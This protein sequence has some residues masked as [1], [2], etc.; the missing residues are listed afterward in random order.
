MKIIL[1][2]TTG[3]IGSE[4]LAQCVRN[5]ATSS[6][7]VL[8]RRPLPDTL[9][10]DPKVQVIVMKDFKV[11]PK[12][13][14]KRLEGADACIWSMGT[15]QANPELEIDYPLAFARAFAPTLAA[16]QKPFRYLHTSGI[17]AEQD[18]T[19][20]LLFFQEGRRIKGTA[21]TEMMAFAKQKEVHEGR[22]E[23]YIV[24]PAMVLHTEGD[25]LKRLGGYL[26]GTVKVDELAAVMI[27]I[28][29][30][31]SNEQILQNADIVARGKLLVKRH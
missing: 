10:A 29:S 27:D 18:Q 20:S 8:S 16:Q 17:L 1:T 6:V 15:T 25:V 28:V 23:T 12:E 14:L 24:K 21:E 3:F 30:N 9:T 11:Y 22:W 31:G 2:G 19:K 5:P 26:L 13:V 4:V 7:I